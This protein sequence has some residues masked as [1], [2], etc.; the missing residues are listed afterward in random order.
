MLNRY[1][2]TI[3]YTLAEELE[4]EITYSSIHENQL[5]PS[6][7]SLDS[8]LSTNI[9]FDNYDRFVD[10]LS[11]K[12]TLHDTVGIIYQFTPTV[13]DNNDNEKDADENVQEREPEV[14]ENESLEQPNSPSSNN[15]DNTLEKLPRKRRKI[16]EI[17]NEIPPYL[18]KPYAKTNLMPYEEIIKLLKD[19]Y[20]H[21]VCSHRKNIVWAL[22]LSEIPSTPMWVG[23]NNLITI[24]NSK[25][26]IVD[27]LPQINSSPTS[28]TVVHE[29]M[30]RALKIAHECHQ[31]SIVVTYDLAIAKMAMQIQITERPKFNFLFINLGAF[32]IEMAFFKA[33]GKYIDSSGIVDILVQSEALAAGSTNGFIDGKHFNR[34]KRLHPI[35]SAALQT[36]HINPYLPSTII[37]NPIFLT[38]DYIY[39]IG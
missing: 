36:L 10:T 11:G 29:T 21:R 24:D 27:Y 8:N 5:I 7:I 19:C 4:T 35:L 33:L 16:E 2:H 30:K 18:I 25:R 32:H 1:G 37:S 39:V 17:P 3:N 15:S 14:L 34:C 20:G 28:Y 9:A 23:F 26:Q 31:E 6:G 22:S 38:F 13:I 12:D